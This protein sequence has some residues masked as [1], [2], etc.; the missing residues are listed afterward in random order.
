VAAGLATG[1]VVVALPGHGPGALPPLLTSALAVWAGSLALLGLIDRETLVLPTKLV[2]PAIVASGCLLVAG[3]W[4]EGQRHYLWQGAAGAGLAGTL[5][6]AWAAVRPGAL[7][8]GDA[9]MAC[10]VALGA[11]VSSLPGT[12]VAV[13]C[14][15]LLAG[16]VGRLRSRRSPGCA[17]AAVALGPF[18]AVG[19][20]L[21]VVARAF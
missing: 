17:R 9:R 11:G 12:F 16:L 19:G 6:G 21:V 5:F 13:S 20:L 8:F 14:A 1:A 4:G 18:L 15:P 7:G 10:L 2:H 3:S